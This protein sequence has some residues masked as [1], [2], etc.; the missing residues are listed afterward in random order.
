MK[1]LQEIDIQYVK[2]IGPKRA[3]AFRKVNIT[4]VQDLLFYFPYRH[5]DRRNISPIRDLQIGES[6]TVI[7]EV[8]NKAIQR[9][10]R[11]RLQV[12]IIDDTGFLT[13]VFFNQIHLFEKIFSIGAQVAFSGKVTYY[14]GFQMVHPDFEF[15][16]HGEGK[17]VHTGSIIPLYSIPEPLRK[18]GVT[19]YSLR[20]VLKNA[21]DQ[22]GIFIKE[23]LPG[24]VKNEFQLPDLKN[25][26]RWMHFPETPEQLD[27]AKKRLKLEELFYFLLLMEIQKMRYS[28]P[29]T[30]IA[31][32]KIDDVVKKV[33]QDLPF[34]LTGAQRRVLREIYTD[35]SR[36]IPMHRLL[37]GDV[38][39]GKTVVALI[40]MLIARANGYQSALMVPTEILADQHYAN[41]RNLLLPFGIEPVLL[42]GSQRNSERKKM[43]E[44][45][46]SDT[47]AI[48]IGTHALIQETVDFVNLGLIVIDEQHRFGVLQR[49]Q[50]VEKGKIP[51]LL[52]M[53]ATPIPR[54]IGFLLYG[55]LD[56]S[57]IDEL[58][59]GR[60]PVKTVWRKWD[61]LP[62][63]IDYIYEQ[64]KEGKQTYIVLPL[65]EESEKL[66]VKAAIEMFEELQQTKL[67][68]IGI[69]L[70]HG[71]MKPSQKD[72]IM[73]QFK[74]GKIKVLVSTTVIEVGVDVPAATMIVIVHAERFGLAQ[75]HQLRGRVG[76]GQEQ[77]YCVLLTENQISDEAKKRMEIMCKTND[78][79][80][81]AEYDLQLRGMGELTGLKQHGIGEFKY[82]HPL[83][84]ARFIPH[85]KEVVRIIIK[86]DPHL[87]GSEN[88]ILRNQLLSTYK[89]RLQFLKAY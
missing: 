4:S 36:D 87:R 17:G 48:V 25:V 68:E 56:Q 80:E 33:L 60:K 73:Q 66:D 3:E 58:P 35:M 46:K 69:G 11:R 19:T 2:G 20:I 24:Y 61:R 22:F 59:P 31:F 23:T 29:K 7:G 62:K 8:V 18:K 51:D 76:R 39:S 75:L 28:I 86:K 49:A 43:L 30:G 37:Q 63:I 10:R 78:G 88:Q 41:F 42:K 15:F 27:M 77:A 55:D 32:K 53:T 9:G 16:N 5:L 21:L 40:A 14:N 47:T 6:C 54:T 79:F 26:V 67:N 70:L 64:G 65:I 82:F 50:L 44:K 81:I 34:E 45:L 84:D 71:R 83:H 38:G 89:D 1:N 85:V 72:E 12:T 74:Q 13:A 52:V 57:K